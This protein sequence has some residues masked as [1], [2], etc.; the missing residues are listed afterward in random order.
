MK[1]GS[2]TFDKAARACVGRDRET[3]VVIDKWIC[4]MM[5]IDQR[6]PTCI[7]LTWEGPAK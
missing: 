7:I 2:R 5:W 6:Y 1:L 4:R 3:A